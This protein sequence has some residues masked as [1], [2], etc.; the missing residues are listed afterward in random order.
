MGMEHVF[1]RLMLTILQSGAINFGGITKKEIA[2]LKA[3]AEDGDPVAQNELG[4]L[5]YTGNAGKHLPPNIYRAT[6]WFRLSA[7]QGYH[8]AQVNFY[9]CLK[10]GSGVD[11][12]PQ[13]ALEWL[14]K[15]AT[16]N[17]AEA[18]LFLAYHYFLGDGVEADKNIAFEL[19]E[20]SAKQGNDNAKTLLL[21]EFRH[22]IDPAQIV[23]PPPETPQQAKNWE[24]TEYI[25]IF[26]GLCVMGAFIALVF[27]LVYNRS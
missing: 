4:A 3:A 1:A 19:M 8:L 27:G 14:K 5:Y 16:Q 12:D 7:E 22:K 21:N 24:M 17:D 18:Q 2:K 15:A 9:K 25:L 13:A 26:F 20:K 23:Q 10:E 11:E 6:Y